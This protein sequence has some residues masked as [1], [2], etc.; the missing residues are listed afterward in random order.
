M[1]AT[2]RRVLASAA[3]AA[4]GT[5]AVWACGPF[6]TDLLTVQNGAPADA[7]GYAR[8]TLGVVKPTFARRYLVQAYRTI[9]GLPALPAAEAV[10][11]TAAA[12]QQ[13][14]FQQWIEIQNREL[15]PAAR[16]ALKPLRSVRISADYS[17]FDNCLAPAFTGAVAAFKERAARYGAR[18]PELADWVAG[19]VSVFQNCGGTPL[20]LPAAT[21]IDDARLRADRDYQTA[22]AYFYA[23]QYDE[24]AGRFRAIAS[25]G[26]SPWRASARY[27][28][29]RALIRSVTVPST[30]PK[31]ASQR[32]AAA[33]RDLQAAL[34][35]RDATAFHASARGLLGFIAARERPLDRLHELSRRLA[36]SPSIDAQDVVDYTWLM[37][38]A[39]GETAA[40][41]PPLD[42]AD[43]TRGDDLT[44][45]IVDT[46][47]RRADQAIAR[48]KQTNTPAALI[49]AL[50]SVPP[51]HAEVPALLAA[52]AVVP[53]ASPAFATASFLRVRLLIQRNDLDGARAALTALPTAPGA[54][55]DLESINLLL[56]A[57]FT[58][59]STLD[60][61]LAAAPR[62]VVNTV[63]DPATGKPRTIS[64]PIWDDDV[65]AVF[66][67]RMPLER[68]VAAAEATRLPARLRLRVAQAAFTR[69]VLLDRPAAA[70][71]AARVAVSLAPA[72]RTDLGRY[73]A[74]S[75]GA[76]RNRIAAL[77]LLRTPGLSINV[78]GRDTDESYQRDTPLRRFGH[79]FPRNWWCGID[80]RADG[81]ALPLI[82]GD[83]VPFPAFV[84]EAERRDTASEL[85]AL[86]A[87]GVPRVYLTG[88]AIDWARARPTDPDAAEALALA[89]EGWR[90]SS[91]NVDGPKSNLPQTAFAL[92]HRQFPESEWAK[93]T[94][95][96]YE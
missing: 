68:L 69:A 73:I 41:T 40:G 49:A 43:V 60:E 13:P 67:S 81:T 54:G 29:A 90:W 10:G 14:A 28:A 26:V 55:F 7:G 44:T 83:G 76:A 24:A 56:A 46:Q 42:L 15:P 53:P 50:W 87:A 12:E 78:G 82:A 38:A 58:V 92:L 66:N 57:R 17:S 65:A 27:L 8:G 22:A 88:A 34:G 72:M 32:F 47:K 33:A 21:T 3:L 59:A 75:D 64:K 71:R 16:T 23:T 52:S 35:D 84:T 39:L 30:S 77:T 37:D 31:D 96:W 63:A 2:W 79:A 48:W 51:G 18:S 93:Q 36:T 25:N 9:R 11:Y 85:D 62:T 19:Q 4:A 89:I 70:V 61:M 95:Y 86:K 94:K 1:N 91:C 80:D 20:V 5:A 6:F 74:A 45:W